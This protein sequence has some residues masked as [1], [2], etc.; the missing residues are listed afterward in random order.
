MAA[1]SVKSSR[2]LWYTC[3]AVNDHSLVPSA[4]IKVSNAAAI[5]LCTVSSFKATLECCSCDVTV[6]PKWAQKKR[7]AASTGA[8]ALCFDS[9]SDRS[10]YFQVAFLMLT[11]DGR[12]IFFS[13]AG[14]DDTFFP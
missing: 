13:A 1:R 6:P 3:C 2:K 9:Q 4:H 5:Y 10:M 7:H 8:S 11:A 12:D 14:V